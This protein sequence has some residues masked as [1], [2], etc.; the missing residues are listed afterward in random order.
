MK[1][2][3]LWKFCAFW[4]TIQHF[5][6][7]LRNTNNWEILF[8][9]LGHKSYKKIYNCRWSFNGLIELQLQTKAHTNKFH[10][11]F[12]NIKIRTFWKK[13]FNYNPLLYIS[14][15][16]ICLYN[17]CFVLFFNVDP[18]IGMTTDYSILGSNL[19]KFKKDLLQIT[20]GIMYSSCR[21]TR[22]CSRPSRRR[23]CLKIM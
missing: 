22:R 8:W 21:S 15:I 20:R 3:E 18:K 7:I 16:T 6:Y 1:T 9:V 13:I 4:Y 14:L 10:L 12:N 2:A 5:N 23:R 17:F 11:T 19:E